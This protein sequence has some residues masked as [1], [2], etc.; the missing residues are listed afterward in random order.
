[1][2]PDESRDD[3]SVVGFYLRYLIYYVLGL[4]TTFSHD[5]AYRGNP[6]EV[7]AYKGE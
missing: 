5:K 3:S 6:F 7:E 1:M 2:S 4:V